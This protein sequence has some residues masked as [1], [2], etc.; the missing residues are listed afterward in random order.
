LHAPHEPDVE[1]FVLPPVADD[2]STHLHRTVYLISYIE[3]EDSK[4]TNA[5]LNH[6]DAH[7]EKMSK[8]EQCTLH[9]AGD[10]VGDITDSWRIISQ[11]EDHPHV[12]TMNEPMIPLH[13]Y[14]FQS[15][16]RQTYKE[17]ARNPFWEAAMQEEYNY[18]L[19]NQTW[20]LVSLPLDMTLVRHRWVYR[21]CYNPIFHSITS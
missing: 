16:D 6:S 9:D 13:C 19:E 11:Y 4:D 3:S 18:L 20:D 1:D 21:N 8:W 14:I 17:V 7:Q 5:Q 2:E 10:L 12:I 15:L